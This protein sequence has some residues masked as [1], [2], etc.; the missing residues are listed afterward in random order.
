MTDNRGYR[1]NKA[2]SRRYVLKLLG[3]GAM[4]VV[5]NA[6]GG[7]ENARVET[8]APAPTPTVTDYSARFAQYEAADEPNG[9]LSKVV[10]PELI[11]NAGGD[12]Q[13]LYEFQVVN[14]ALM[15]YMPC[16]CG[17]QNEDNHRNNRDCYIDTVNLDGSVVFD[18]M[19]PT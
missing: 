3:L 9:D 10:W 7:T 16:F 8:P 5:V 17:C 11:K 4:G 1:Q 6:C 18:M 19:A 2:I 13:K 14:G 12:V 15:K